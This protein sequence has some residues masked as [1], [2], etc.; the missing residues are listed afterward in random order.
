MSVSTIFSTFLEKIEN[1]N[2]KAQLLEVLEYIEEH[3]PELE[4]VVKWNQPMF[5]THGTF[6]IGFSTAKAHFS[7][8]PENVTMEKFYDRIDANGYSQTKGM[9]RI[10]WSDQVDYDLLHDMI[11]F[12]IEDKKDFDLFWRK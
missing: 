2:H 5:Q 4:P 9:F 7:V 12:N 11:A 8:A 10:K 1:E 3:F 6:I